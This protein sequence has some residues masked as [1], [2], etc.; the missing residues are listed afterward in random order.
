MLRSVWQETD[1][2]WEHPVFNNKVTQNNLVQL[3]LGAGSLR[4]V[5][6]QAVLKKCKFF[7]N[8]CTSQ[9][10]YKFTKTLV[11][12]TKIKL[13]PLSKITTCT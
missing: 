10:I 12:S 8:T 6:M 3:T 9:T 1:Y 7:H 13:L 11:Y 4:Y 5:A 2:R